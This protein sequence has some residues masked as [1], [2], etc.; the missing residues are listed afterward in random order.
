M[1]LGDEGHPTLR[2]GVIDA[3]TRQASV[4]ACVARCPP[5]CVTWCSLQLERVRCGEPPRPPWTAWPHTTHSRRV[6]AVRRRATSGGSAGTTLA[7]ALGGPF[8]AVELPE[9]EMAPFPI[10]ESPPVCRNAPSGFSAWVCLGGRARG[11]PFPAD[12]NTVT[13]FS[14]R[15]SASVVVL[16]KAEAAGG[17][18]MPPTFDATLFRSV[19]PSGSNLN[20]AT[21]SATD[22]TGARSKRESPPF[23]FD[24]AVPKGRP[25]FRRG[26]TFRVTVAHATAAPSPP[27]THCSAA[28]AAGAGPPFGSPGS[29][30]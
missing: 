9:H 15:V 10:S 23:F 16:T 26:G 11:L 24:A 2:S 29:K 13:A 14:R 8:A 19:L 25:R 7:A 4:S 28:P 20:S 1:E 30:R 6:A 18:S 5:R 17:A 22:V 27:V 3:I 21:D 12:A